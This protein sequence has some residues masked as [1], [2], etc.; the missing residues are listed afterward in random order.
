MTEVWQI[1]KNRK[2]LKYFAH[3]SNINHV[4]H[5][6]YTLTHT[7][8]SAP[9]DL[10]EAEAEAAEA[11]ARAAV[12]RAA[13]LR[14]TA[15]RVAGTSPAPSAAATTAERTATTAKA[16]AAKAA[17]LRASVSAKESAATS[18]KKP[19]QP[20]PFT[21]NDPPVEVEDNAAR[22][23]KKVNYKEPRG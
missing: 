15:S 17:L 7:A 21:T 6:F 19:A 8:E 9:Q 14:A 20:L 1:I 4:P 16:V 18:K 11:E 2:F 22:N 23:K 10:A 3:I 5:N 12:E 13:A